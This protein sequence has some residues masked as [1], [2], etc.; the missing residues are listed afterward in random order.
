MRG[1]ARRAAGLGQLPRL[2]KP[3]RL[4]QPCPTTRPRSTRPMAPMGARPMGIMGMFF[5]AYYLDYNLN[6][7][8]IKINEIPVVVRFSL[9]IVSDFIGRLWYLVIY[10]TYSN[11]NKL[12]TIVTIVSTAIDVGHQINITGLV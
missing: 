5:V 1:Q 7:C 10:H 11:K 3:L 9:R 6:L 8:W 2:S 12:F 4:S